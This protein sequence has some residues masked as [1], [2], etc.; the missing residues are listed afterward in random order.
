[1][2]T[3]GTTHADETRQRFERAATLINLATP[4][5]GGWEGR[6]F[7]RRYVW[8]YECPN[9]HVVRVRCSAWRGKTPDTG[10]GAILCPQCEGGRG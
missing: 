8:T 9:G 10:V 2:T 6:G 1:M 7:G 4:L 3:V 5:G